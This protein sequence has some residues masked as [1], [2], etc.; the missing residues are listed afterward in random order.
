[1][2]EQPKGPIETVFADSQSIPDF[3]RLDE[4]AKELGTTR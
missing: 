4:F 3:K 1:M 2:V